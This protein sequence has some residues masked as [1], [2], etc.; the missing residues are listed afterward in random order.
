M[1]KH[2][3]FGSHETEREGQESTLELFEM[4]PRQHSSWLSKRW[5]QRD[6][7]ECPLEVHDHNWLENEGVSNQRHMKS[8]YPSTG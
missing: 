3:A 1:M 7:R 2:N 8:T 5:D 4:A 6:R